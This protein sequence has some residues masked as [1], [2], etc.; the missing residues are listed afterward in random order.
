MAKI[1]PGDECRL[2]CDV[3]SNFKKKSEPEQYGKRNEIVRIVSI[4]E[5]AVIVEGKNGN[6]Y[7]VNLKK[8]IVNQ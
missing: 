8:L 5:P 2:S 6:R 1:T 7:S 4:S 3:F